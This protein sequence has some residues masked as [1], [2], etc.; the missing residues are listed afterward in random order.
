[1]NKKIFLSLMIVFSLAFSSLAND[2]WSFDESSVDLDD[3]TSFGLKSLSTTITS[4]EVSEITINSLLLSGCGDSDLDDALVATTPFNLATNT[5]TTLNYQINLTNL[6]SSGVYS[7]I[8][9][10]TDSDGTSNSLTLNVNVS[11]IDDFTLTDF[12]MPSTLN[13][14]EDF[15]GS[16]SI[17]NDG[18]L[19][20]N[21]TVNFSE[22]EDYDNELNLALTDSDGNS[23]SSGFNTGDLSVGSSYIVNYT[24]TTSE[25]LIV[26]NNE[27][28]GYNFSVES[29]NNEII[30]QDLVTKLKSNEFDLSIDLD[31]NDELE[32]GEDFTLEVTVENDEDFDMEDVQI[33]VW[34]QNID[35]TD[36]LE[37]ESTKFSLGDNEDKTK[38]FDFEIPYNVD[39]GDYDI[40]IKVE[41]EDEDDSSN[42]FE[43]YELFRDSLT[44]EKEED[45]DV[46][47]LNFESSTNSLT[48]GTSFTS[49]ID[50]IN[51]GDDDLD[52]MYLKLSISDL[53][54]EYTSEEFDLDS[55]DDDDRQKQISFM[56]SLPSNLTQNELTLKFE[57]YADDD[58]IFD[59]SYETLSVEPCSSNSDEELTEDENNLENNEEDIPDSGVIYYPTGFAIS[60]ILNL[61]NAKLGLWIILDLVLLAISVY[62]ISLIF[63]RKN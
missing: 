52:D 59:I 44:V 28:M 31:P 39:A 42:D 24:F 47:F 61:E 22:K 53:D 18:N 29:S 3:L 7:C 23:L 12:G 6:V 55:T 46:V 20:Q 34:I 8:L 25:D 21:F 14:G 48:C 35:D 62:L 41:G 56:V 13:V 50:V 63:R 19:I 33:K 40:L 60:D 4:T 16:F 26:I 2:N 51:V 5:T 43:F 36:D 45:D 1:M 27:N 11:E 38:S 54:F 58:D 15:N 32:P 10:A 17:T 37:A 57:A 49:Y 30:N 9:N